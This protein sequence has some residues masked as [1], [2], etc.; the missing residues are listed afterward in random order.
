MGIRRASSRKIWGFIRLSFKI[1]IKVPTPSPYV[2]SW[3]TKMQR[4]APPCALAGVLY[5]INYTL[6]NILS[7][8]EKCIRKALQI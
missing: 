4:H 7:C 8:F 3:S 5:L 1:S 2:Y 6:V